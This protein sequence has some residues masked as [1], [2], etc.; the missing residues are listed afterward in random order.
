MSDPGPGTP[1]HRHLRP[2]FE[3]ECTARAA[4][5]RAHA[6]S[7]KMLSSRESAPSGL[8]LPLYAYGPHGALA[9]A[10]PTIAAP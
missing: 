1:T 10:T 9:V 5:A 7:W 2:T 8:K 4:G 3:C 6:P